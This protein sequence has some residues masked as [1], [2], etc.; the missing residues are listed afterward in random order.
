[1]ETTLKITV[2]N[3]GNAAGTLGWLN[4]LLEDSELII[5]R[6]R[7]DVPGMFLHEKHKRNGEDRKENEGNTFICSPATQSP[8]N[9]GFNLKRINGI[10]YVLVNPTGN[11]EQKYIFGE[12]VCFTSY[13]LTPACETALTEFLEKAVNQFAE[14]YEIQ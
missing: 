13:P 6:T 11:S 7:D 1:M 5:K 2:K 12:D 9:E 14:W 4:S 10:L 3:C 8:S